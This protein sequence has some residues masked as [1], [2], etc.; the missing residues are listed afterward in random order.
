MKAAFD[1]FDEQGMKVTK[2][3]TLD[4]NDVGQNF[5]PSSG[6]KEVARQIHYAMPRSDRK[7]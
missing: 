4:Q 5:Y 1:C 7:I 6:F 2:I 3:E